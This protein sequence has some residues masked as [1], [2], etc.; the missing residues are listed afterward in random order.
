METRKEVYEEKRVILNRIIAHEDSVEFDGVVGLDNVILRT[1]FDAVRGDI[2]TIQTVHIEADYAYK[3]NRSNTYQ[4]WEPTQV[5]EIVLSSVDY[6]LSVR[7]NVW[8][9]K[10]VVQ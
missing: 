10:A 2:V 1:R 7:K 5:K 4:R 3:N 8:T 6:K 9:M